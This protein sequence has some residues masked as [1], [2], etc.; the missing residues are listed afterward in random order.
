MAA[1]LARGV[2]SI[3]AHLPTRRL[4]RSEI[5][6]TFGKGGGR[7]TRA[8]ASFD[9]DTTTMAVEACRAGDL[10]AGDPP[11]M[12]LW[13]TTTDPAYLDKTNATAIHAALGVRQRCPALDFGGGLRSGIGAL[14]A[15]LRASGDIIVADE[16]GAVVVPISH[17]EK[18]A[19]RAKHHAEWEE[20]SRM[21]L[22]E[23]GDLRKYYPL[24]EDAQ[25]EFQ[26]WQKAQKAAGKG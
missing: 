21:R 23:G 12:A 7:G 9:E 22:S 16:D 18:L 5:A 26:A 4:D 24:R 15:A 13:F 19:E 11:L 8:V 14:N 20:F 17:A 2:R 10:C 25:E 6:S 3:G 1:D